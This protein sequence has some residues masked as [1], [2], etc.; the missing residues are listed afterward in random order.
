MWQMKK[1]NPC[2]PNSANLL[3][4]IGQGVILEKKTF[5]RMKSKLKFYRG[6]NRK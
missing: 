1:N 2:Q 4:H 5:T 3:S 6:E